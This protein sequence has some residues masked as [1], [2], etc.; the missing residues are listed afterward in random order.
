M[1]HDSIL[2]ISK[3]HRSVVVTKTINTYHNLRFSFN[4]STFLGLLQI[5][6]GLLEDSKK[7]AGTWFFAGPMPLRLSNQKCQKRKE[8]YKNGITAN[9]R[10]VPASG[11]V[12]PTGAGF[13]A[14]QPVPDLA[15]F[16]DTNPTTARAKFVIC[17][18]NC[19][20][21]TDIH[22]AR[23]HQLR[24]LNKVNKWVKNTATLT[25]I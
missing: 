9:F 17:S 12:N 13:G 1:K 4:R 3:W 19:L 7:L 6:P 16:D 24:D 14:I 10:A 25:A 18:W 8:P 22:N 20:K 23:S 15:G 11:F 21:S 2:Y 5:R